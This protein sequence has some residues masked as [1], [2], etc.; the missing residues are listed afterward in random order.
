VVDHGKG[1]SS[2]IIDEIFIPFFTTR[3][4][5]SGIGLS[6]ARQVMVL[7]NGNGDVNSVEGKETIFTLS[8]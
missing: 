5:G 3:E 6:F 7:H 1:I 2:E 8:F 4:H